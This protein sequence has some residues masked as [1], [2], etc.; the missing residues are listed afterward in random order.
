MTVAKRLY[1]L[2]CAAALGLITVT[3]VS[4]Y[5]L[6]N[7]FN[8]TNFANVNTVPSLI[9]IQD[10]YTRLEEMRIK[11]W[12]S[13]TADASQVADIE[14]K[15]LSEK[16]KMLDILKKYE[17]ENIADDKDRALLN[18]DLE[19]MKGYEKLMERLL[20]LIR[21]NKSTAAYELCMQPDSQAILGR[22]KSAIEEHMQYNVEMGKKAAEE[23][24]ASKKSGS[25][26]LALAS[27]ITVVVV[28]VMGLLIVRSLLKQLGGEPA[29]AAD[30]CEQVAAGNLTVD[31][32]IRQGD[33]SSL[34]HSLKGMVSKLSSIIK[35]VNSAAE[36]LSSAS[37]E[38]SATAQTM[39]QGASEQ[40]ASVEETTASVEEMS[41][42]ISQ[43]SENAKV[44]EGIAQ[45][46]AKEAGEGGSAVKQTVDAMK[47][48]AK[49]IGIID[50]IAY[51][52]NL[53]ALNAAIE[54]AR[55]GEHGKGFA[56]V[57]AEVRKLA[58]RSQVAA[59]E[60]GSV[61]SESVTLAERA[62]K[63][64]EEMVPSIG[65]TADLVQE[66]TS[67]SQEQSTGVS[68]INDAMNQLSQ[69]TQQN[70]A[71][72]EELAATAEEM[73]GQADQLQALMS[74]FHTGS[75]PVVAQPKRGPAKG[76]SGK[77]FR[78]GKAGD[79]ALGGAGE[80]VSF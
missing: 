45:K 8:T 53:L 35:D 4:F 1:L 27:L 40:A 48:I 24:V 79:L 57:A 34:L 41:A 67:A 59:Q 47:S 64:L 78:G 17:A 5:S 54:A 69:L 22:L 2:I 9:N 11:I 3:G 74:F 21:A 6:D 19:A 18:A 14:A 55:A 58:E 76:A 73:S 29:Y 66:I 25:W 65:K 72:S 23:A 43:N 71:A 38:V 61:A 60:I 50:D 46:S 30:I 31:I 32:A 26:I 56:V 13:M 42:S 20:P 33:D 28:A 75:R 12:A 15:I 80:F 62:G 51:Q 16:A 70:A 52:T 77:Q 63:L 44:T 7:V 49:K 36:S 10:A 68:Q 39:S 37:E